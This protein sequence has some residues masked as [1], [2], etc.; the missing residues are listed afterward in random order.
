MNERPLLVR[1]SSVIFPGGVIEQGA[2]LIERG[3]ISA[4]DRADR[5]PRTGD[6]LDG[7]V[8]MPGFIDLHWHGFGG[9]GLQHGPD[10]VREAVRQVARSGVTTCY[11]GLGAGP[12]IEAI[13]RTVAGASAVVETEMGGTRLAGVFMEGPFISVEKKGAWNPANLRMPD[14][15][16]MRELIAAS[17]D[18]IRRFNVAPE[19]PGALE[20][21]RAARDAGIVVS[22]GHSNATYEES[23]AGVEAGATIAPATNGGPPAQQT[24]RAP[25]RYRWLLPPTATSIYLSPARVADHGDR[26]TA[27]GPGGPRRGDRPRRRAGAG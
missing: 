7:A 9:H 20:F 10:E 25:A 22:I 4:V 6:V 27:S 18:R 3:R 13:A 1:A 26:P 23:L 16:E 12:S 5:L 21:I 8:L 17:E 14:V 15:G 24:R 11:A 19:L 2:V